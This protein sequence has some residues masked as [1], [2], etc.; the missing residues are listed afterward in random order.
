MIIFTCRKW[1]KDVRELEPL[2]QMG[3]PMAK[4]SIF[5]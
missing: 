3:R 2:E 4:L 5:I 1:K